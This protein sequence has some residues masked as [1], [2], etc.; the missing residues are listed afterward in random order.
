MWGRGEELFGKSSSPLPHTPGALRTMPVPRF[1]LDV[2]TP[3]LQ[4]G[5]RLGLCSYGHGFAALR[6]DPSPQKL[7]SRHALYLLKYPSM[8]KPIRADKSKAPS[9]NTEHTRRPSSR[10]RHGPRT[11]LNT[12]AP[13][14]AEIVNLFALVQGSQIFLSGKGGRNFSSGLTLWSDAT[15]NCGLTPPDGKR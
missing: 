12:A 13:Q 2:R 10:A 1:A 5:L 9:A 11:S 4:S 14:G 15:E 7:L 3:L 8:M 6:V